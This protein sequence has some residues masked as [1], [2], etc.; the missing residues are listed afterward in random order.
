LITFF[1]E[2][3]HGD[4]G[5]GSF[6]SRMV[7]EGRRLAIPRTIKCPRHGAELH[8]VGDAIAGS[9]RSWLTGPQT[10]SKEV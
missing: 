7:A 8:V 4:V 10:F 3:C 6:L 5:K 1:V 2:I 9:C